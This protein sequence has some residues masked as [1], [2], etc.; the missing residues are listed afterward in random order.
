MAVPCVFKKQVTPTAHCCKNNVRLA[1]SC[2][3]GPRMRLLPWVVFTCCCFATQASV[4][5]CAA[6]TTKQSEWQCHQVKAGETMYIIAET[7]FTLASMLCDYNINALPS[8][9]CSQI[10]PGQ[11]LKVPFTCI[12]EPGIWACSVIESA[13]FIFNPRVM[14][15]YNSH[16]WMPPDSLNYASN[17][18]NVRVPTLATSPLLE[19]L[20]MPC[21]P[22]RV[23]SHEGFETNPACYWAT[24]SYDLARPRSFDCHQVR[25]GDTCDSLDALYQQE[26]LSASNWLNCSSVQP[27]MQLQ[28]GR[29]C[30]GEPTKDFC[31]KIQA[32][33]TLK[34]IAALFYDSEDSFSEVCQYNNISDCWRISTGDWLRIPAG[35]QSRQDF[36]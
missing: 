15:D 36:L 19:S 21:Y 34:K 14:K 5:E 28:V 12:E 16:L 24:A 30:I 4:T 7:Y 9:N 18:F 10:E 25:T 29:C 3:R 2:C 32:K 26:S 35:N 33:D 8:R 1:V 13:S 17:S 31:Y 20:R 23:N 11:W 6:S 27:G 22:R